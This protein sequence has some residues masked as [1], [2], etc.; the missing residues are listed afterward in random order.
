MPQNTAELERPLTRFLMDKAS[1]AA[2][3]ASGTFELTPMCNFSCRMCYIRQTPAQVKAHARP[4]WTLE[5]WLA[6]ARQ[7][8]ERGM[9]YL[10]LTGGEPLSWP[11]FWPLYEA[12]SQM[13]F[14]I[15]VNTNGSLIDEAAAQ[16]FSEMPP[17]RLNITLYGTSNETYAQLCAATQG[18]DQVDRA[19]ELLRIYGVNVKLNCSLTPD[20]V[21]DLEAM[22]AYAKRRELPISVTS[23]M[24][25]PVRREPNCHENPARFT[26][27]EAARYHLLAFRL[28]SEPE[29][30]QTYLTR[31]IL[32]EAEP[33][34]LDESCV[35][36]RDGKIRCRAGSAAFWISWDGWLTPCGMMSNPREDLN[37]G[38]FG[39]AWDR[40]VEQ[41]QRIRLSGICSGC[42]DHGICH[43]CAASALAETGATEKV[44]Q[45]LC[46]MVTHMRRL[47]R[48]ELDE[49]AQPVPV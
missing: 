25:P 17:Q 31:L 41:S 37:G 36:P 16:K 35:D 29:A 24:F 20:N 42:R 2:I 8:R 21:G 27:E 18:F 11:D 34:G 44:P 22:I 49:A 39:G 5:Q 19:L 14:V 26:P 1:L 32:G 10:L 7:A 28:Q 48:Q 9:L 46:R 47:A 30:Y 15:S 23:Y 4:Q 6:V 13:G 12:L 45:Y 40:L 38:D 43:A 3:P 33:P